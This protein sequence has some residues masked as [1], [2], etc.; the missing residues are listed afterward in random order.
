MLVAL[1]WLGFACASMFGRFERRSLRLPRPR[2]API[3]TYRWIVDG[4]LLVLLA[5][6][7]GGQTYQSALFAP[8]ML[9]GL[10]RLVPALVSSRKAAWMEDRALLALMLALFSLLGLLQ[11][12][13]ATLAVGLLLGG[14][15]AV[16]RQNRLTP[17]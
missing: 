17:A 8:L 10:L 7:R 16:G 3:V 15:I 1:A 14:I 13:V 2:I 9:L 6:A 4:V 12:G 5:L 11:N